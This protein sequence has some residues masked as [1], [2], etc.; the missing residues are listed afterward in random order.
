MGHV[1]RRSVLGILAGTGAAFAFDLRWLAAHAQGVAEGKSAYF[2]LTNDEAAVLSA[3]ADRIIPRDDWPSASEAGVIDYIDLQLATDW[4]RGA[5]L[6]LEGPFLDGKEGQ[7]Y[8]LPYT[9]AEL[10]RKALA[11]IIG[12][13]VNRVLN[14][15]DGEKDAYL[16]RL[17]KGEIELNGIPGGAFFSMLRQNTIEGYFA[18]PAYNGNRDYAGWRMLGFP[19]A[20]A[21]Y[22]T[23]IDRYNM[24]YLRAPS[25]IA[26][27]PDIG[28]QVFTARQAA[29]GG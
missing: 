2:Y 20:D 10:Y 9:P 3:L 25:G 17:D 18:D 12:N 8:Q 16:S 1:S 29:G 26:H 19:G 6:Y 4:G 13:D 28:T 7:G 11:G 21:Y 23:E 5:G 15:S 14:F 24:V 22:L 27:R